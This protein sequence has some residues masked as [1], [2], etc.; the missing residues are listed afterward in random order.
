MGVA[1]CLLFLWWFV[2][3]IFMMFWDYPSVSDADRREH[4]PFLDGSK[5]KL[6]AEEAWAKVDDSD[7]VPRSARLAGF[8]GRPAYDFTSGSL[9]NGAIVSA[10]SGPD[11][12]PVL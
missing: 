2:S 1:F 3:G 5:V 8:A 11:G 10:D 7:Q 6:S 4:A 9:P 12:A